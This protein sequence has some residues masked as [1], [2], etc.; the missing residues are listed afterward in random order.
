[1]GGGGLRWS[2]VLD[3]PSPEW[4]RLPRVELAIEEH[5]EVTMAAVISIPDPTFQEVGIAYVTGSSGSSPDADVVRSFVKERLA[6][7]KVPKEII[8]LDELPMLPIG[9][10]DKKAL[11][12]RYA[13]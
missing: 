1:M 7:Y 4:Q 11:K 10:V 13:P 6:N 8:V 9:K 3:D 5:P 2:G 12:T